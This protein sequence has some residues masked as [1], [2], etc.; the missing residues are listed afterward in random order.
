MQSGW[1]H[2]HKTDN[3]TEK[4]TQTSFC[5]KQSQTGDP[6]MGHCSRLALSHLRCAVYQ[7]ELLISLLSFLSCYSVISNHCRHGTAMLAI[8][9]TLYRKH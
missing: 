7:M 4:K 9:T 1:Q 3:E 2:T 8:K 5:E 6:N